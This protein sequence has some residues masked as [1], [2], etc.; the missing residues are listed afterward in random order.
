MAQPAPQTPFKFSPEER[1]VLEQ[2]NRESFYQRCL[3]LSAALGVT[4]Y[5]GVKSGS[6]S[7][8]PRYGAVPKVIGAVVVGYFLGKLSYQGKCA[9]KLMALPNSRLG[10]MLRNK[11]AGIK[12]PYLEQETLE[13]EH[14][15]PNSL[16]GKVPSS[17]FYSDVKP[18]SHM[19]IDIDRPSTAGLDDSFRPSVDDGLPPGFG[20]PSIKDEELPPQTY[21]RTTYEELRKKNREEYEQKKTKPYR[22][23]LSSED[24]PGALEARDYRADPWSRTTPPDSKQKNIYGDVFEK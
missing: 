20:S 18:K 19:D 22:G 5:Y 21:N 3:P 8:N 9:E 15:D 2:C 17:D 13:T 11:K 24:V 12:G 6:L 7:P 1:R 10:A 14:P 23:V 16:F 4:T